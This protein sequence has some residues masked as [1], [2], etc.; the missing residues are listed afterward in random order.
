MKPVHIHL[1][2]SFNS[3]FLKRFFLHNFDK[4]VLSAIAVILSSS[5]L[6]Y[7]TKHSIAFSYDTEII[8][9]PVIFCI[10]RIKI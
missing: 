8:F 1:Y 2:V 6:N 10:Q 4:N 7:S 9:Q 5:P 3:K